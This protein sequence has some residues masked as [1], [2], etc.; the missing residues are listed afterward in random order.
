[1]KT[2]QPKDVHLAGYELTL[3]TVLRI[4][5]RQSR[6]GRT[7]LTIGYGAAYTDTF[8]ASLVGEWL[9]RHFHRRFGECGR[10]SEAN[11]ATQAFY[12]KLGTCF[13]Q[14]TPF[15]A[16][17]VSLPLGAAAITG[18]APLR[19]RIGKARIKHRTNGDVLSRFMRGGGLVRWTCSGRMRA[20]HNP[21]TGLVQVTFDPLPGGLELAGAD[22]LVQPAARPFKQAQAISAWYGFGVPIRDP[23]ELA[24]MLRKTIDGVRHAPAQRAAHA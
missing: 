13:G 3:P 1:M 9:S 24:V 10:D 11:L 20:H 6:G 7:T 5:G 4:D 8:V 23:A 14:E 22:K 2:P 19:A 16:A 12:D 17:L 15:L 21:K 18:N